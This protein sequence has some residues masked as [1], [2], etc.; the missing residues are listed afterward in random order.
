MKLWHRFRPPTGAIDPAG[1]ELRRRVADVRH[2]HQILHLPHGVATPGVYDPTDLWQRLHLPDDLSGRRILDVGARDGYFT[3]ACESRGAEV[4]AVDYAAPG[5]T[6]FAVAREA[7]G[8]RAEYLQA[9]VYDL[10]PERIGT[11]DHVL[12]LGVLYHLRHPLLALDRLYRLC[13]GSLHVESLICDARVFTAFETGPP[14][15]QIAPGLVDVPLAQF[16]P[17]G[18]F[19]RDATNKWSPNLAALQAIVE[20]A[21]FQVDDV[22]TWGDRA[23]VRAHPDTASATRYWVELDA[24]LMPE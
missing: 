12:F 15:V 14:L 8:S 18:R 10:A 1:A 22:Q 2:W 23:L 13:R 6:G 9:N 21:Q 5:V 11:F 4:L 17:A 16:L 20:D 24:G 3:F 19:H 7:L